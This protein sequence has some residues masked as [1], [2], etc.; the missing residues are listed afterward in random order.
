MS[1][2]NEEKIIDLTN[3][4]APGET[5]RRKIP[6]ELLTPSGVAHTNA[7]ISEVV[8]EVMAAIAPILAANQAN[9]F[10]PAALTTALVEAEKMRRMPSEDEQA[11]KARSKRERKLM[12][13]ELNELSANQQA[14]RDSC[15]HKYVNGTQSISAI[16]NYPDRNPRYICHTCMQLFQPRRWDILAPT[17]E[18]PRGEERIVDAHPLYKQI[19]RDYCVAHP[20]MAS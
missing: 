1:S 5:P 18:F 12:Q 6:A 7:N 13:Q 16:R 11:A 20:D 10:T 19:H 4:D 17:E 14:L 3:L 2:K 15:P 9:Q 8:R